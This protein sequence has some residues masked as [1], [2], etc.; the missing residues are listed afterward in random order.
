[1]IMVLQIWF[2]YDIF[3]GDKKTEDGMN[4]KNKIFMD[5]LRSERA[6]NAVK[7]SFEDLKSDDMKTRQEAVLFFYDIKAKDILAVILCGNDWNLKNFILENCF[8]IFNISDI[9]LLY[10]VAYTIIPPDVQAGGEIHA[11]RQEFIIK[12]AGLIG[13]ILQIAPDP[14]KKIGV[15]RDESTVK[16]L[17]SYWLGMLK[18]AKEKG[19]YVSEIDKS[20]NYFEKDKPK[21]GGKK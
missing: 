18:K 7:Q 9:I 13:K 21:E 16:N 5:G 11:I 14:L 6:K 8:D 2:A 20:I 15:A 3:C 4:Q 1:M 12:I 17:Q 10:E 19:T